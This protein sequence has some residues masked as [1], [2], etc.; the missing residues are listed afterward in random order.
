MRGSRSI[1][2]QRGSGSGAGGVV[3]VVYT[4]KPYALQQKRSILL[5]RVQSRRL[6]GRFIINRQHQ[7]QHQHPTTWCSVTTVEASPSCGC[8]HKGSDGGGN[9]PVS[10]WCFSRLLKSFVRCCSLSSY[11]RPVCSRS[12]AL[13]H[14]LGHLTDSAFVIGGHRETQHPGQSNEPDLL[15]S[16]KEGRSVTEVRP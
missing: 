13:D 16:R 4:S 5:S 15:G 2:A 10:I 11:H 9:V 3:G 8:R 6:Q 7:H 14:Q 1:D 12:L